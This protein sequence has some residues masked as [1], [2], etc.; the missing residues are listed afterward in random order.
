M[1]AEQYP[2]PL[3]PADVD[4]RGLEY[5]PLF[6][7]HLFGSD[8]NAAAT[9]AEWRAAV[10]L[11]WAAWNQVPAG[12]LPGDEIALCRLADLGRDLKTW[13]KLKARALHGFV[14]CSDG[15]LYHDFVCAQ[16]LIA[17]DKRVK[18]RERKAQWRAARQ[19]RDVDRP[20]DKPDPSQ[21]Q[22]QGRDADVPADGKRRDGTGR[23]DGFNTTPA[24]AG[25]GASPPAPA[26]PPQLHLVEP[27]P[28]QGTKGPPDCPHAEVLRLW[29][30]VLPALPQHSPAHWRGTRADHLRARW[31]ETAAEKGWTDQQQGLRYLRKLFGYVGESAFLTGREHTPGRRPFFAE[32]AWLVEPLNW[33]KVIEGKFHQPV[34][35]H[36]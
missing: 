16:A 25:G 33:A 3:V 30:E 18:E 4:L 10:T 32:L 15:R 6:G 2:A 12:S 5:M 26:Q 28:T 24:V 22:G 27:A 7:N 21:P 14:Q 35:E 8:F 31:R 19:G 11:W 34:Q 29:A 20:P 36:A 9:D 23:D 17:W 1:T 13:R